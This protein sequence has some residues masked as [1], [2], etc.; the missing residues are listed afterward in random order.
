MILVKT[1]FFLKIIGWILCLFLIF[2]GA[3][4]SS[5]GL[6]L[7]GGFVWFEGGDLNK[8]LQ[9]WKDYTGDRSLPPNTNNFDASEIHIFKEGGFEFTYSFASRWGIG[10]SQDFLQGY[11][12]G[13]V[14]SSLE[15]EDDYFRSEDDCG[16]VVITEY[17][18]Q[19]P[20]YRFRAIPISLTVY[21]SFPLWSRGDVFIGVG[22]GY[23]FGRLSYKEQY[24]YDSDYSDDNLLSG[25]LLRYIDQYS[26]SGEYTEE[27]R[28]EAFGLHGRAGLQW[29]LSA[30]FHLVFEVT[31]RWVSFSGW[32]GDKTDSYSWDHT[33]SYWGTDTDQGNEVISSGGK[34]WLVDNQSGST[35]KSYPR[36]VFSAEEP[37]LAS[38]K[39]VRPA[40][41]NSNGLCF[42][43]GIRISL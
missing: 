35:G 40:K 21:H 10:L 31:G 18:E 11:T 34:L 6:K 24:Q 30:R 26:S 42:R 20:E 12:R 1:R 29:K 28:S 33:Y 41:I 36:L 19:R 23:Y 32:T 7:T 37:R 15:L 13:V 5:L 25:S 38:F 16:R 14:S 3:E 17:Q 4:A 27:S 8:N 2:P 43:I 39:N 22:G 9:G